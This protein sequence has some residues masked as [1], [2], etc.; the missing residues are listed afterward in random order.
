MGGRTF[1]TSAFE[2]WLGNGKIIK[3][4]AS[5]IRRCVTVR[6]DAIQWPSIPFYGAKIHFFAFF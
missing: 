6:K 4:R 2:S 1:L 5:L 3:P